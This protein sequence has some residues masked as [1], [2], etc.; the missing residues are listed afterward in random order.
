MIVVN[1]GVPVRRLY[2]THGPGTCSRSVSGLVSVSYHIH[3]HCGLAG[4][5]YVVVW[6]V[7]WR[8]PP[9]SEGVVTE[10]TLYVYQGLVSDLHLFIFLLVNFLWKLSQDNSKMF[11]GR[12]P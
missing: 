4:S 1:T 9:G 12:Y 11:V 5:G 2:G 8:Q 7:V 10:C 3:V 6:F